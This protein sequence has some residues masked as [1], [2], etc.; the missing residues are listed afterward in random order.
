MDNGIF[1][2]KEY[3]QVIITLKDVMDRQGMKRN[4]LASL[5]GLGYNS[6]NRYYQNAPLTSVDLDIL[7]KICFV[8]NCEIGDILKYKRSAAEYSETT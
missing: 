8:L 3:G 1:N 4:K 7:A 6:I 5:T 2:L